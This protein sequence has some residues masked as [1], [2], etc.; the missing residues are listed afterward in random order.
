L[1]CL[2]NKL[3]IDPDINEYPFEFAGSTIYP[4]EYKINSLKAN[5]VTNGVDKELK[6]NHGN[7]SGMSISN[8]NL[9]ISYSSLK[10]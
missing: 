5:Y 2:N 6:I 8:N 4:N 3:T 9:I 1:R 7:I 10:E